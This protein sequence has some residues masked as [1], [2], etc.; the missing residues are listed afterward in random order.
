[1]IMETWIQTQIFYEIAMSIG[2]SLD[3]RDMLKEALSAYLKKLNCS[4][5][6]VLE[7]RREDA[8]ALCFTPVFSLPRNLPLSTSQAALENIVRDLSPAS[9]SGFLQALPI[10]GQDGNDRFFHLMDLPGFGLLLLVK[11]RKG[12]CPDIV[13]S[14]GPINRKLAHSCLAC[15]QSMKI[16]AMN[17]QLT[18]EI[19]ERKQAE[20]ELKDLLNELEE[21]VRE[22]TLEIKESNEA[23]AAVNR[24]LNDII[25]FLPDA[26]MVID[27][28]GK[29]IA[30]NRAMEE[31][32]GVKAADM[33]GK[34]NYEHSL[35]FYGERRPVL[36]D[37]AL[38]PREGIVPEYNGV[39][40]R[41]N[42]IA[43]E[44]YMPALRNGKTYL[45]G[46]A[47]VLRDSNG[48]IAGAIESIRDI[49]N[50]KLGEEKLRESE[51]KYR[52]IFE[53]AME[54]IYRTTPEGRLLSANPAFARM[55]GF[56][57]PEDMIDGV[58]SIDE[59]LCVNPQDREPLLRMLNEYGKVEQYE[60]EVYRKDKS[61]FWMSMNMR[62]VRDADGRVLYFE[63][64]NIDITER[65]RVE[66]ALIR[67][68]EKY[69]DI[70]E[71]SVTG[72][73]P[74]RPGR[75]FLEPQCLYRQYP[76]ATIPPRNC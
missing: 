8:G 3:L 16:E 37:L 32:S 65:K 44:R 11:S 15:L 12:L 18:H 74:G 61:R 45:Y 21:R 46:I 7:M 57:S 27:K 14:L 4:A 17:Q 75:T 20:V 28:E 10:A 68:E 49:T 56:S 52:K 55:F 5:G 43:G 23:L 26:T 36:I 6:I 71:N 35:P 64:T 62:T 60:V 72:I 76:W 63:G 50:R 13:S 41:A 51:E 47:S 69:R 39:S 31:M 1:M 22:R 30:W 70:F 29:V 42:E 9:L 40:R 73:Y 58:T 54:G 48:N 34:G 66:A 2:N 33:L 67:A 24:R 25:E 59:Q 53:D 19:S 38:K